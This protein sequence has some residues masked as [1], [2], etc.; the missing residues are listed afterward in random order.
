M[1]FPMGASISSGMT[2]VSD[3]D[4]LPVRLLPRLKKHNDASAMNWKVVVSDCLVSNQ[5][6]NCTISLCKR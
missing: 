5:G 3:A 1:Q 4:K 6:P 2:R